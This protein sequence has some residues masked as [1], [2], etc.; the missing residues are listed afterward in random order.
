MNIQ[1][2]LQTDILIRAPKFYVGC[3]ITFPHHAPGFI[4]RE[5]ISVRKGIY[6]YMPFWNTL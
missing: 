6:A 3:P 1:A 4:A 5:V 2:I